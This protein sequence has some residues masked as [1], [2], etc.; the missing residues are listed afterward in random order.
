MVTRGEKA[1][2]AS[3][4]PHVSCREENTCRMLPFDFGIIC[5]QS[6][7]SA[8]SGRDSQTYWIVPFHTSVQEASKVCYK[9]NIIRSNKTY[10]LFISLLFFISYRFIISFLHCTPLEHSTFFLFSI[11]SETFDLEL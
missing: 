3:K 11:E 4:S 9:C 8:I 2:I 10:F 1:A 7:L 5:M 6:I